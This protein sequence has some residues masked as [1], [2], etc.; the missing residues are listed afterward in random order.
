MRC[1]RYRLALSARLD[2][3]EAGVDPR[4]LDAH[5]ATCEGCRAWVEGVG[6]VAALVDP[7]APPD[8]EPAV[9]ATLLQ[10]TP[11][12]GRRWALSLTEWRILT[13]VVGVLQLVTAWPGFVLGGGR[14]SEHLAH[15]LTTWDLGLAAG[16]VL[17]ALMPSRAWGALPVVTA[18]VVALAGSS[19]VDLWGGNASAGREMVHLLEVAGLGCL[20]VLARRVPR[21]SVVV[22]L[23]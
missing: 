12:P 18:L 10:G 3:E 22:R 15:E 23:A 21:S 2:A 4:A 7:P 5:V 6:A 13:G 16:F 20:W 8:L 14:A 11:R 9:L 19:V 1:S 17:L